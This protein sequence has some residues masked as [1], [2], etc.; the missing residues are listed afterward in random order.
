[1]ESHDG[2]AQRNCYKLTAWGVGRENW[3]EEV[4]LNLGKGGGKV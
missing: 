4:K 3:N 1:M 2:A